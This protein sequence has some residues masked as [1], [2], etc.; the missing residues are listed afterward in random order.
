MAQQISTVDTPAEDESQGARHLT[1]RP[2][3]MDTPEHNTE[4]QE[5][6]EQP[7]RSKRVKLE[8]SNIDAN[9]SIDE[10]PTYDMAA[11]AAKA[12]EAA[13]ANMNAGQNRNTTDH[14][15]T[16]EASPEDRPEPPDHLNVSIPPPDVDLSSLPS[17]PTEV[18]LWVAKQISNFGDGVRGSAESELT[19][20]RQKILMHPPAIY[21]RRFDEDDDPNKIA[22]RERVREENRERKKRWRESNA[23][24]NKDNDL[25]CRINK[26][27][28]Q[29]FGPSQTVERRAWIESEFN[30]RRAKRESKERVRSFDDGFP[31]F[32]FAPGFGS[33]LF[34][35]PGT[36]P[37][38]ETNT[39]GL[40]LANALLGVGSNGIGPNAD[41]AN[42]LRSALEG[43]SIDSRPFTEALRAMAANPEIM[44]GINAILGGFSGYDDGDGNSGDDETNGVM[45]TTETRNGFQAGDV[46][47]EPKQIDMSGDQSEIVKALNAA[48]AMLNDMNEAN[49]GDVNSN[50]NGFTAINGFE[51]QPTDDSSVTAA[52]GNIS[53]GGLDEAQMEALLALANS[54][55]LSVP[56][57]NVEDQADSSSRIDDQ[58]QDQGGGP[59]ADGDISATLQQIIQQVMSRRSG[60]PSEDTERR[61]QPRDEVP[62]DSRPPISFEKDPFGVTRNP[63]SA[64]S[65]LLHRAGMSINTIMP[66]AQSRA[67]SQLYA[68]LSNHSRSSTPTGGINP[69]HASAFGSTGLMN[70]RMLARPNAYARPLHTLNTT[71]KA[72]NGGVSAKPKNPEEEKKAKSFG[73][74]PLPGTKLAISR[75]N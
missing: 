32:A 30:K 36:G 71:P 15:G 26:R 70:Q 49:G 40:L 48:T 52:I 46:N 2:S 45:P 44:N 75:R 68:R 39:A 21:T 25:R 17:D 23:E 33:T 12:A 18:A 43:G 47:V 28:K 7:H 62:K 66:T 63:A 59:Q 56:K 31:G 41:A 27:A 54:Q 42:A 6:N 11:L 60:S 4:S 16:Q 69:A 73:F 5:T 55:G 74:P 67:T 50:A 65:S 20:D 10:L 3:D 8:S 29:V 9:N 53:D 35:A 51:N 38:G 57:S 1:R 34:P 61:E 64:L 58:H 72:V 37:Q 24:R 14:Q 22:E 13:I 19:P